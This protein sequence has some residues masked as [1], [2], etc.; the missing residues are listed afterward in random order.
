MN[1]KDYSYLTK[2]VIQQ[3]KETKKILKWNHEEKYDLRVGDMDR[4]VE[5]FSS[6]HETLRLILRICVKSHVWRHTTPI[7]IEGPQTLR[8]NNRQLR[9]VESERNRLFLGRTANFYQYHKAST[10]NQKHMHACT[11][12]WTEQILFTYLRLCLCI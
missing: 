6:S 5:Y 1:F 2:W 9:N 12:I 4:S 3:T 7:N 10:E 11:T 8:K